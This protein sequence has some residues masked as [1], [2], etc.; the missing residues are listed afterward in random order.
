MIPNQCK[1]R[2]LALLTGALAAIALVTAAVVLTPMG[3]DEWHLRQLDSE[4]LATCAEAATSLAQRKCVRA[5]PRL[6]DWLRDRG[7][8]AS[9]SSV[10]SD[11]YFYVTDEELARRAIWKSL[12]ALEK[13]R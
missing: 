5:I 9:G 11:A 12:D 4:N 1:G 13:V 3:I 10:S 7:L 8:R 2:R 6:R